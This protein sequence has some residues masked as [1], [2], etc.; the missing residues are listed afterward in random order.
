MLEAIHRSYY[1]MGKESAMDKRSKSIEND[2][3]TNILRKARFG[4]K[5]EESTEVYPPAHKKDSSEELTMG[6]LTGFLALFSNP[7]RH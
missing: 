1:S 2:K 6:F 4:S 3:I 7:L 5:Y